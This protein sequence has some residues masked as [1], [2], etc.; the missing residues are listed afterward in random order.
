MVTKQKVQAMLS[1]VV[2]RKR[3]Q[4]DE[5]MLEVRCHCML[6]VL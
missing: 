4:M 6:E 3:R 5:R 1:E 2:T